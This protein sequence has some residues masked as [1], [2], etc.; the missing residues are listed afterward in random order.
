ML[1]ELGCRPQC[2]GMKG[3]G[4]V[5]LTLGGVPWVGGC[6]GEDDRTNKSEG[7]LEGLKYWTVQWD[8]FVSR[9]LVHMRLYIK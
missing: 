2:A 9:E 5:W 8:I 4:F 1:E 7:E 6:C 3:G